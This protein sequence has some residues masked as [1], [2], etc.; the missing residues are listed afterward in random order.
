M[1][2]LELEQYKVKYPQLKHYLTSLDEYLSK[3]SETGHEVVPALLAKKISSDEG[4]ALA[5]LM[6]ADDA[7]IVR[8]RYYV[9]CDLKDAVISEYDTKDQIPERIYCPFDDEEHSRQ[10]FHVELV[11]ELSREARGMTT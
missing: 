3:A 8:P 4:L 2:F 1:R 6:L 10:G 5:L 7:G 9:Y 11:F